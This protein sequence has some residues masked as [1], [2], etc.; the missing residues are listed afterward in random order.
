MHTLLIVD[1]EKATRDALR[2]ALEES[3]D[4]YLAADLTQAKQVLK[5]G[6]I[7][8]LLT[9]LRLGGD[10]GMEVLDAALAGPSPPVSI[11]M[12]AYGSVDTAV[13]AM[14]PELGISSPSPSIL[15]KSNSSLSAPSEAAVWRRKM[16]NSLP[17]TRPSRKSQALKTTDSPDSSENLLRW[18][19]S[20]RKSSKSL[21]LVPLFSSRES[22]EPVKNSS[23]TPFTTFPDARKKNLSRSIAP[24]SPLNF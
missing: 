13:E 17:K 12:T 9:D 10:S 19:S 24:P 8:L 7:D 18:L 15:M 5:T 14:R 21:L 2:M 1:D 3:F 22:Q 20:Q 16:R 11:M 6:E 4:C 23:L